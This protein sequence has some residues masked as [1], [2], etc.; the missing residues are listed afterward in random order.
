MVSFSISAKSLNADKSTMEKVNIPVVEGARVFAKFDE[1]TPAVINY[2]TAVT[3]DDVI[4]FYNESYGEPL[5]RER[6]RGRLTLHYQ[7]DLNKFV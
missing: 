1:K 6:K 4:A 3:E 5:Q 7:Q 2:F